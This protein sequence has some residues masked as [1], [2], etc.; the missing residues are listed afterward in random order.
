M[1]NLTQTATNSLDFHEP[2]AWTILSVEDSQQYQDSLSFILRQHR[3]NGKPIKLLS[4]FNIASAADILRNTPNIAVILLDI[5]MEEDDSGIKFIKTIRETIGNHEARIIVLTGQ[6]GMAPRDDLLQSF[7]IDNYCEKQEMS[8]PHL[9]SLITANIRNYQ[10]I[11]RLNQ[12]KLGLQIIINQTQNLNQLKQLQSFSDTVLD[13]ISQLCQA[14]DGGIVCAQTHL[15][16]ASSEIIATSGPLK[17]SPQTAARIVNEQSIQQLL[18][19]ARATG[20]HQFDGQ[21]TLLYF[22]DSRMN[23]KSYFVIIISRVE[24]SETVIALLQVFCENVRSG[25]V[26]VALFENLQRLAFKDSDLN[27]YNRNQLEQELRLALL[28]DIKHQALLLVQLKSYDELKSVFGYSMVLDSLRAIKVRLESLFGDSSVIARIS[29]GVLAI[30]TKPETIVNLDNICEA[31]NQP[32]GETTK[33]RI[34]LRCML[35]P[36]THAKERSGDEVLADAELHLEVAKNRN[37]NAFCFHEKLRSDV[38]EQMLLSEALKEA[39]EQESLFLH[40][41]PKF[42]LLSGTVIGFEALARWTRDDGT[43]VPPDQFISLA[44]KAGFIE[45]LDALVFRQLIQFNK[46]L[47]QV[48]SGLQLS[49]NLSIQDLKQPS[50]ID[51]LIEYAGASGNAGQNLVVEIT[52]SQA[53]RSFTEIEQALSKLRAHGF[54][55]S[56]DDFGTGY[57]SLSHLAQIPADVLKI[58]R[59][60]VNKIKPNNQHYHLVEAII[61]LG[62]QFNLDIVAEGIEHS[63]QAE[64]LKALGCQYGQGYWFSKPLSE[65][66]A[67]AL[68]DHD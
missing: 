54:R 58:D 2:E 64:L 55:I 4:A 44:E 40:Y 8:A 16:D 49:F 34:G 1:S 38:K 13:A 57:S 32:Y 19:K 6:P 3:V 62:H 31:L 41:Q 48:Q 25:L 23:L 17:H 12:A 42:D 26:N 43:V 63:Y 30:I 45:S 52:E 53:M 36:L 11:H 5:V 65:R 37:L 10:Q 33:R 24:I 20:Q 35:Y 29:R 14:T 68:L 59:M 9:R 39:I 22:N 18:E 27:I 66:D 67:L 50:F 56:I 46:K 21:R 61:K 51:E 47:I 15:E 28:N 7:D 60:F